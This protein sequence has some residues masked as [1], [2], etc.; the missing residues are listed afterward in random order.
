M[1]YLRNFS[2]CST[3]YCTVSC[4]S[5]L[6]FSSPPMS[7]HVVV[8]ISTTVSRSADGLLAPSAN[9]KLSIVTPRLSST[10]A[11]IVSSSRSIRSIFSRI[12]CIAASEQSAATSAPT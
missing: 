7:S 1:P 3:G 4:S 12:C 11:S 5:C 8:G 10:S 2:G 6:T 9:R